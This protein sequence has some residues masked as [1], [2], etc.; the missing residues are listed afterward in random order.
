MNHFRRSAEE[1]DGSQMTHA[2]AVVGTAAVEA[3]LCSQLAGLARCFKRYPSPHLA[4]CGKALRYAGA[5]GIMAPPTN[6]AVLALENVPSP[7]YAGVVVKACES[8]AG[9]IMAPSLTMYLQLRGTL[10]HILPGCGKG[11]TVFGADCTRAEKVVVLP[12]KEHLLS[13]RCEVPHAG[14]VEGLI[15]FGVFS[16][17]L[18]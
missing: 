12:D 5:G 10:A 17:V 6:D 13:Y 4:G 18:V 15:G 1:E 11:L 2:F 3:A 16:V 7:Q 9:G 8:G 14:L